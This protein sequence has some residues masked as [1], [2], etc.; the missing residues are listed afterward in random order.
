MM[1]LT[2]YAMIYAMIYATI[3]KQCSFL[4][5]Q[6]II[7]SPCGRIPQSPSVTAPF[8][9]GS[10]GFC[11]KLGPRFALLSEEGGSDS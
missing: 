2:I 5:K 6:L 4:R 1:N 8:R 3:Y 11:A 9:Q 10:L 7:V